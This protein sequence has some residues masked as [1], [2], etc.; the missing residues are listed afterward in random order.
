[1][2]LTS[3]HEELR[4]LAI[5]LFGYIGEL[6]TIEYL[7][8]LPLGPAERRQLQESATRILDR[9]RNLLSLRPEMFE[10]LIGHL[11]RKRGLVETRVTRFNN[12]G[13]VD[14]EG[15]E[16]RDGPLRHGREKWLIQCKRYSPDHRVRREEVEE[17]YNACTAGQA[18]HGVLVTT[19]GFTKDAT[20][21]AE[22]YP[23][24]ELIDG[25]KLLAD[26]KEYLP[27]GSYVIQSRKQIPDR[28]TPGP[29]SG[30]MVG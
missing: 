25:D 2:F 6:D 1:M 13:G 22:K 27:T 17:F 30:G 8:M 7:A 11:Y 24:L 5:D 28:R 23:V 26:L 12:D 9:P 20:I 18:K 29:R 19:S 4:I 14:I 3:D 15:Y 21:F 10:H 16:E